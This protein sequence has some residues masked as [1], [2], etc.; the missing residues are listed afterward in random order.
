MRA[1]RPCDAQV[2]QMSLWWRPEVTDDQRA[3]ILAKMHAIKPH[4]RRPRRLDHGAA[5]AAWERRGAACLDA[6]DVHEVPE[7]KRRSHRHVVRVYYRSMGDELLCF[8]A[9]DLTE[10]AASTLCSSLRGTA[11]TVSWRSDAPE[12]KSPALRHG[13]RLVVLPSQRRN[14]VQV[15]EFDGVATYPA[16]LGEMEAM[17][18]RAGYGAEYAATLQ[19]EGMGP[20]ELRERLSIPAGIGSLTYTHGF[21][22]G[23]SQVGA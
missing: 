19:T 23:A 13:A 16:E 17:L 22:R 11:E 2:G 12:D 15:I 18:V 5:R 10:H 6:P 4:R 21:Q 9:H 1:Q 14:P 20:E 3:Q 8:E 7:A